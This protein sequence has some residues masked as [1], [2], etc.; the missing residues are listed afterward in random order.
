MPK[1]EMYPQETMEY[2]LGLIEGDP[3]RNVAIVTT[4]WAPYDECVMD[5]YIEEVDR[6]KDGRRLYRLTRLGHDY[7]KSLGLKPLKE[8]Y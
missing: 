1:V 2:I 3:I 8:W 4:N 5:G 7:A 6:P